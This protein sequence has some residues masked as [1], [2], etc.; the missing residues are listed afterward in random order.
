M[1]LLLWINGYRHD[2][3]TDEGFGLVVGVAEGTVDLLDSAAA[4][5][6]HLVRP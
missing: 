1:V 5:S 4:I 3:T 6:R 2:F